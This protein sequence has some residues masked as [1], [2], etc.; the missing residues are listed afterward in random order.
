MEHAVQTAYNILHGKVDKLEIRK[1]LSD[2]NGNLE[3]VLDHLSSDASCALVATSAEDEP[4]FDIPEAMLESLTGTTSEKEFIDLIHS[5]GNTELIQCI[6]QLYYNIGDEHPIL[7][8]QSIFP[9]KTEQEIQYA[10]EESNFDIDQAANKLFG[11]KVDTKAISYAGIVKRGSVAEKVVGETWLKEEPKVETNTF[12]N[13]L[14]DDNVEY[15]PILGSWRTPMR[16]PQEQSAFNQPHVRHRATFRSLE[17][18]QSMEPLS[19]ETI[20]TTTKGIAR[21]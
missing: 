10:F 3:L 14:L 2:L 13:A 11:Q 9:N 8:L 20:K 7:H 21:I 15:P 18:Q 1:L 16:I 6:E 4:N 12:T 17:A 19:V 5:S